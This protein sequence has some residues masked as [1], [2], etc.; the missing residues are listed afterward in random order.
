MTKYPFPEG[1][2]DVIREAYE[3]NIGMGRGAELQA[4]AEKLGVPVWKVHR[5]AVKLN[6]VKLTRRP[7]VVPWTEEEVAFLRANSRWTPRV[8]AQKM[9]EAGIGEGRTAAAIQ[10]KLYELRDETEVA[11]EKKA[12]GRFCDGGYSAAQ[13]ARY[14]GIDV[15]GVCRWIEK[16]LLRAESRGGGVVS[17]KGI[18]WR[19][20]DEDIRRFMEFNVEV[21]DWRKIPSVGKRWLV[22]VLL[23]K[24]DTEKKS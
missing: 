14:F 21:T 23:G 8:I 10:G 17:G 6:L 7:V 12:E 9:R 3:Q 11:G 13:I 5:R 2:D 1:A 4:L 20:T 24:Q 15:H 22:A 16:G 18:M 19:I